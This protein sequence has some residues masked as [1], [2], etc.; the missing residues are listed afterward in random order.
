MFE[1][2]GSWNWGG[3]NSLDF[4]TSSLIRSKYDP[5]TEFYH[6]FDDV[7]DAH[8]R[9]STRSTELTWYARSQRR[10]SFR[11]RLDMHES[12]NS[13]IVIATFEFPGLK[14][15]EVAI[16]VHNSRL[17]MSGESATSSSHSEGAYAV[18]ERHYGK[19]SRTLQLPSGTKPEDVKAKMEHGLLTVTKSIPEQQSQ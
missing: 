4:T 12:E 2:C 16:D 8:F 6:L 7:F 13:N 5:F 17:I 14:S 11:P 15:E 1:Q 9:S 3:L 10:D 18:R 19:F